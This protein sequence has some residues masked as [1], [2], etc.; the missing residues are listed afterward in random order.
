MKYKLPKKF[1]TLLP[2]QK[3]V[4][5]K[6]ECRNYFKNLFSEEK[7]QGLQP[8]YFWHHEAQQ[9]QAVDNSSEF[10]LQLKD[11]KENDIEFVGTEILTDQTWCGCDKVYR[12]IFRSKNLEAISSGYRDPLSFC[13]DFMCGTANL[14]YWSFHPITLR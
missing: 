3:P 5:N 11:L 1:D 14:V 8:I 7:N 4:V 9:L 2:W 10:S 12:H 6:Y 13:F